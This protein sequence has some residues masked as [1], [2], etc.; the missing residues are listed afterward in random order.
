[1]KPLASLSLDLDNEWSYLKTH[2]DTAWSELP[3]YLDV[4]VP[5]VLEV[6]SNRG[7]TITWFIVGQDA[8]LERNGEALKS[9]SAAGHEIGNH[10]FRHEPWLH[11]YPD[12]EVRDE[13]SR[14]EEAIETATGFHPVGFR[15]PGYSLSPAVLETLVERGYRY[16][17]STLPTIIGPVARAIY[18]RSSKLDAAQRADRGDLF[19]HASEALRPLRAY[20]WDVGP[21]GLVEIP[22]TVLPGARVPMHVSYLLALSGRSKRLARSYF[23]TALQLCKMARVEPSLLLHPLDFLGGDDVGSL[24]FFPGM[25]MRGRDKTEM[26]AAFIEMFADQFEVATV[27]GH[28]AAANARTSL[29]IVEPGARRPRVGARPSS[30]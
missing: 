10:S 8:A 28:A 12:A 24:A 23:R 16:D 18:F 9:I 11:K 13:L 30:R 7:V 3:S 14:A 6:L 4:V 2:G 26:T 27:G 29:P 19:G 17:C 22:V 20:R 1:M 25:D 15:G 5:R 21:D